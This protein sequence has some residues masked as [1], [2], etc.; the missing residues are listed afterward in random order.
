ME[1]LFFKVLEMSIISSYVILV[2]IM[3]R[4]FLKKS[5]KI[6]SYVLWSVVLFRL[7]CPYTFES[8]LSFIPNKSVYSEK[9]NNININYPINNYEI[10]T[11]SNHRSINLQEN[12]ITNVAEHKVSLDNVTS[13]IALIW[14]TG[15]SILLFSMAFS[16]FRL[17]KKL[18]DSVRISENIYETSLIDTAFVFGMIKPKIYVQSQI[19]E[20]ERQYILAHEYIHIKRF[21]NVI[22]L[23]AYFVVI[24]HWFNPLVWLAFTLMTKD[25]EMSCDE[26]VVKQ[27]GNSIKKEYSMSLLVSASSDSKRL[28]N[29]VILFGQG[30]VKRRIKNVLNYKKPKFYVIAASVIVAAAVCI[31]LVLNPVTTKIKNNE[32]KDENS[33]NIN[34]VLKDIE[35]ANQ[36]IIRKR[37]EGATVYDGNSVMGWIDKEF[38]SWTAVKDKVNAENSNIII[39]INGSRDYKMELFEEDIYLVKITNNKAVKYYKT[40]NEAYNEFE[41]MRKLSSNYIPDE[42]ITAVMDGKKTNK[43][44]Y[45]DVPINVDY[46]I[47]KIGTRTYYIYEEKGKYYVENPYVSIDEISKEAYDNASIFAVKEEERLENKKL[48]IYEYVGNEPIEKLV[49]DAAAE[50]YTNSEAFLGDFFIITPRIFGSYEE[51]NKIKI[52]ATVYVSSCSL[53]NKVVSEKGGA[54]IPTAI[55]YTKNEDGIY[56]LDE[57]LEAM[58]GEEYGLSINKFC[59]MPVSGKKIND[60]ANEM[61]KNDGNYEELEKKKLNYLA[62]FLKENR[63][64][65]VS[66]LEKGYD[67]ADKLIPLT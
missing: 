57:Y 4:F 44:S 23:V 40:E 7:V 60:L 50:K 12:P 8:R 56:T 54:I 10:V 14:I 24:L 43:A 64:P 39:Y 2:V 26:A 63:Q 15:I 21:D 22:K 30:D 16:T 35:N 59:T 51:E 1:K 20:K 17:K 38:P 9:Y 37:A 31:G 47:L 55:T 52:F 49:C 33:I 32:I 34:N 11:K 48:P 13:I 36:M 29:P 41:F 66:Y 25:M 58:D 28:R 53:N 42:V 67:E 6:F 65:G 27:L 3:V 45:N 19:Q 62:K 5:P 18:T 61:I 46:K